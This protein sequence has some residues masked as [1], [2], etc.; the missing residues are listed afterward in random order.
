MTPLSPSRAEKLKKL[1]DHF[2]GQLPGILEELEAA[3]REGALPEA[4]RRAHTLAGTAGT[5]G[6][7][8][9]GRAARALELLLQDASAA[10]A[11]GVP[12]ALSRVKDA[13]GRIPP[14]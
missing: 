13:V 9:V 14:S 6:F 5:F 4:H 3:C 12:E 11:P 7:D 8:D 2:L 1:R 10:D